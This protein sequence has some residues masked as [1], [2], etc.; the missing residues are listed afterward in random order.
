MEP[1]TP[2]GTSAAGALLH[3]VA[4]CCGRADGDRPA[5]ERASSRRRVVQR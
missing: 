1:S 4:P 3:E 5:V 2:Q